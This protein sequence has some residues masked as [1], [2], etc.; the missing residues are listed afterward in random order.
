[1]C[2]YTGIYQELVYVFQYKADALVCSLISVN[3]GLIGDFLEVLVITL[4]GNAVGHHW[5]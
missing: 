3:F 1:M 5:P 2:L 4:V